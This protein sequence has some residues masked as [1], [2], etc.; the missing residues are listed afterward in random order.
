MFNFD[1]SHAVTSE[2]DVADPGYNGLKG[3]EAQGNA[4]HFTVNNL[5]R[6]GH[7]RRT[8]DDAESEDFNTN[9]KL[10]KKPRRNRTTFTTAQ[11]AAL[12]KVFEKTHYPDAFV[13]EDLASKV[14]LS[15]ARVQVWFQNRRAKFR[16]NE[17]S[18]CLQTNSPSKLSSSSP[19]PVGVPLIA[20]AHN[21]EKTSFHYQTHSSHNGSDFQYIMPWKCAYPQYNHEN[22]YSN[23][24]NSQ[25]CGL[26]SSN[27]FSYSG[28]GGNAVCNRLDVSSFRYRQDYNL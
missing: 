24:V 21:M 17:R 2:C 15:E 11:L 23:N 28:L 4:R 26:F 25:N 10:N 9:D 27:P 3:F 18:L 7:K 5:L 1:S 13:R 8:S 16:R 6:L 12:E 19:S 20:D 14:S 22:I